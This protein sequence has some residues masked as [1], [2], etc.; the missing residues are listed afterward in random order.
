MADTCGE[1][2]DFMLGE[3]TWFCP[4]KREQVHRGFFP[5]VHF[6]RRSART[7]S[8][9]SSTTDAAPTRSGGTDDVVRD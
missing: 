5:C 6:R 8:T 3:D 7:D 1:C 2:V 4:F 9:I